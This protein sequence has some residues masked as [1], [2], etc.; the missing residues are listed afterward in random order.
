MSFGEWHPDAV[1]QLQLPVEMSAGVLAPGGWQIFSDFP[2][3]IVAQPSPEHDPDGG[4]I[5]SRIFPGDPA[6]SSFDWREEELER[7]R[8]G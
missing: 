8:V 3:S 6:Q 4:G 1:E 2:A 7:P 5:H